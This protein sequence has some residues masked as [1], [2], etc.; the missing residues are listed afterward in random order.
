[1]A[2]P[3]S[4][5][6]RPYRREERPDPEL[7]ARVQRIEIGFLGT[8][9]FDHEIM[10]RLG[11]EECTLQLLEKGGLRNLYGKAALTY[12]SW[13]TEFISTLEVNKEERRVRFKFARGRHVMSFEDLDEALG[14]TKPGTDEDPWSAQSEHI[15]FWARSTGRM[16]PYSNWDGE[17]N[18]SWSHPCLRIIHKF[19]CL[20]FLGQAEVNKVPTTDLHCI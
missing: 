1:M 7:E 8:M 6:L 4:Q 18:S 14:I 20:T 2:C 19:I 12:A 3:P 13:T 10:Q 15:V 5:A 16:E 11:L 9:F 17:Y